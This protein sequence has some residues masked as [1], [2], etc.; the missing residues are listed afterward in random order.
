[1]RGGHD[2]PRRGSVSDTMRAG[3][4][5]RPSCPIS[6]SSRS[7]AGPNSDSL[8]QEAKAWPAVTLRSRSAAP[9]EGS[10]GYRCQTGTTGVAW[11]P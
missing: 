10:G 2:T 4:I 5:W 9:D 11:S 1:V 6:P 7:A 8:V 3:P